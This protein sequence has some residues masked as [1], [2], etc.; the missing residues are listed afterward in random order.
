LT[1]INEN[2]IPQGT[3][4]K[5][6]RF[7][8]RMGKPVGAHEIQRGLRLS[9]PS[10]S[11]YHIK[12]LLELGLIKQDS[13]GA[14]YYVDRLIFEGM[15][16]LGRSVIPIQTAY[17]IFFLTTLVFMLTAFRINTVATPQFYLFALCVN[18]CAVL[19]PTYNVIKALRNYKLER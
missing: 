8:Y 1:E 11:Q 17:A 18:I 10:V 15:I 7:I 9:S 13:T 5:V 2:R 14:G 4:L 6:Y 19:T 16:R 3:T 12:R